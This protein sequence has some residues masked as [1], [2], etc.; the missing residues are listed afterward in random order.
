MC[1]MKK[2]KHKMASY[3]ECLKHKLGGGKFYAVLHEAYLNWKNCWASQSFVSE[4][5]K[6]LRHIFYARGGKM[7]TET[8]A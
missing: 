6:R 7:E 8:F 1:Q 2:K 5:K 4:I 3:S